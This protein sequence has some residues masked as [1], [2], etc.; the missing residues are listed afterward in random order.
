MSAPAAR[1]AL[2]L[3]API[4]PAA[5]ARGPRRTR[6]LLLALAAVLVLSLVVWVRSLAG[7]ISMPLVAALIAALGVWGSPRERLVFTQFIA[8]LLGL[9]AASRIDYL[10]VASTTIDGHA[11]PSDVA[12]VVGGMGSIIPV[13]GALLTL[14]GLSA[15]LLGLRVAWRAPVTKPAR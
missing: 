12:V 2:P 13:W 1:R 4:T 7:W 10:F 14:V 15:L 3:L 11:L 5:L 8:L 6:A 9:D